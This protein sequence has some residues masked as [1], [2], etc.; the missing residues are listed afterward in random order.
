MDKK[1]WIIA[2]VIVIIAIAAAYFV[3]VKGDD[4]TITIGYQPSDHD[5]ALF[6]AEAQEQYKN[7]GLNVKTVQ[8]KNGGD[9][10]T[11]MASGDVDIGYLGLTPAL[12]GIQNGVPIKVVSGAQLE[13]SAIL[14][15][16]DSNINSVADLKGKTVATL[17][18]AS[19]QH[20]LLSYA[21]NESGLSIDDVE[22]SGMKSADMVTALRDNK[23]DAIFVPEPF[24]TTV[25]ENG[26]G[27]ILEDSG[28]IISE[29]P[30]CVIVASDDFIKNHP[31]ETKKIVEINTNATE[32]I[33]NNAT[34]AAALLP[35]DIVSNLSIEEISL[36]G[37]NFVS[38]LSD[39]YKQNVMDFMQKEVDLGVLNQKL[40]ESQIFYDTGAPSI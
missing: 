38:G 37:L 10:L 3:F 33:Q 28:D 26:Y 40:T 14:V 36:E 23:V 7:Q 22:E 24:A 5:A 11:A 15:G 4:G 13:G 29:H 30:C 6:V 17:G 27:R 8:F 21:L 16:E 1:V 32:F 12:S 18:E 34:G 35:D 9:M 19:I 25:V 39:A 20:F 2:A 31:N